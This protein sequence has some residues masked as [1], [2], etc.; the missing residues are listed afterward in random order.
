MSTQHRSSPP[1]RLADL[2]LQ[3]TNEEFGHLF[4]PSGPD[5][6]SLF[7]ESVLSLSR[8]INRVLAI[9]AARQLAVTAIALK[10]YQLRHGQYPA[11]LSALL[12]EFA[13]TLPR[14][15][16]DGN[17]LRYQLKPDGSFL[18]YSVGEDGIDNGGD[19]SPAVKSES[20]NWSKGRDLVWPSPATAE[21]ISAYR[22]SKAK[23]HDR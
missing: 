1:A 8:I 5:L 22:Q 7:S 20:V 23:K 21:E 17:P 4:D 12:P 9:E 15:P 10:R 16:A 11:G 2:G 19:A 18:L 3:S 13:P 6:R 14:D